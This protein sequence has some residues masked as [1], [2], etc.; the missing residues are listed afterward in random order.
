[1]NSSVFNVTINCDVISVTINSSVFNVIMNTCVT[2]YS[3]VLNVTL[4]VVFLLFKS[5][6]V[7][8]NDR[9]NMNN[10]VFIIT[11]NSSVLIV[12]TNK[13]LVVP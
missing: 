12:I 5:I 10:D 2:I 13:I 6:V 8:S 11:I 1:M 4:E 7:S 3:C 9:V